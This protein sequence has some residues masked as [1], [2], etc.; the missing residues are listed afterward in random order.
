[1]KDKVFATAG[2]T[3]E[4][5]VELGK[6]K[7][8]YFDERDF[9]EFNVEQRRLLPATLRE[10][11]NAVFEIWERTRNVK[12]EENAIRQEVHVGASGIDK[13]RYSAS[14]KLDIASKLVDPLLTACQVRPDEVD[15]YIEKGWRFAQ[16]KDMASENWARMAY[17]NGCIQI[18]HGERVDL[19]VM[20]RNKAEW[21][22]EAE[23]NRKLSEARAPQ[24]DMRGIEERTVF[25]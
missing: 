5:V 15:E 17:A 13:V 2:Q 16:I 20:V 22:E 3:V 12:P 6:E 4:S 21:E 23:A 8:V 7:E 11:Y 14:K 25:N 9:P 18:K 1:M 24:S 10:R 19:I